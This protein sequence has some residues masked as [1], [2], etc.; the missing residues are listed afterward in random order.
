MPIA[1]HCHSISDRLE[2]EA[3]NSG[4]MQ[5]MHCKYPHYALHGFIGVL[6]QVFLYSLRIKDMYCM[7]C[8]LGNMHRRVYHER[9]VND[10][11][12]TMQT[13]EHTRTQ[14]RTLT[15]AVDDA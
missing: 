1:E 2:Y 4:R 9:L 6:E 15:L 14:T 10:N 8:L 3:V 13:Q 5:S 7:L 11:T 12:H